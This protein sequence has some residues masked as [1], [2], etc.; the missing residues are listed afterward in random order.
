MLYN[1]PIMASGTDDIAKQYLKK[2]EKAKS[3]RQNFVD[4]FEECYEY[5]LPQGSL[6]I[7]KQQVKEGM[8]RY[9]MKLRSLAYK[10]LRLGYSKVLFPILHVG[11]TLQQV[12]KC[13]QTR[14]MK[15]ITN[16][17]K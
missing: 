10:S 4:L 11:Q 13:L 3:H 15:L 5:A 12:V 9:L 2:Y 1:A 17:M 6:F 8:T 16:L 14:V 7:M